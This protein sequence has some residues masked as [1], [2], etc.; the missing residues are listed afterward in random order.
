[1]NKTRITRTWTGVALCHSADPLHV[2]EVQLLLCLQICFTSERLLGMIWCSR[3]MGLVKNRGSIFYPV[4]M[5][6]VPMLGGVAVGSGWYVENTCYG[7]SGKVHSIPIET[8]EWTSIEEEKR[9]LLRAAVL[10]SL[11]FHILILVLSVVIAVSSPTHRAS[12]I[13]RHVFTVQGSCTSP[14]GP[15]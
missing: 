3:N 14:Q 5:M 4:S 15:K 6:A 13:L 11:Q 12:V 9:K 2:S 8:S 10:D 1:M 7:F